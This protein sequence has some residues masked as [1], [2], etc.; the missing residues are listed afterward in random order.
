MSG[1][2]NWNGIADWGVKNGRGYFWASTLLSYASSRYLY[3]TSTN[4]VPKDGY[5]KS[6]GLPLRCV[7]RNPQ[8]TSPLFYLNN[9]SEI[10]SALKIPLSGTLSSRALRSLPLSAML[11][12]YLYWS[13]GNLVVRGTS[14]YFWASTPYA[15]TYSRTLYFYSTLVSPKHGD[16]K[17]NGF[18]LRCVARIFRL[19]Y[20]SFRH[21]CAERS[22]KFYFRI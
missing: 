17:P 15:Y 20:N 1:D 6:R 10:T 9:F 4:V 18:T 8:K 3:F 2:Y 19:C 16:V 21:P 14:G 7:A 11:S 13:S 5:V 12:G 22:R